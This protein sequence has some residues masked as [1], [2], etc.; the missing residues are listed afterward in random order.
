MTEAL[1]QQHGES[2]APHPTQSAGWF[3]HPQFV[4]ALCLFF[5]AVVAL[6]IIVSQAGWLPDRSPWLLPFF[7]LFGLFTISSGYMH[8]R[9]GYVSFDRIAQV[10]SI[11]VLGPIAAACVNGLA[12]LLWPLHRLRMGQPLRKVVIASLHNAGVMTLMILGCGLLYVWLSG[13]V[14]L[15][16]LDP[17]SLGQLLVL[18]LGMQAAN[19]LLMAVYLRLDDKAFTWRLHGFAITMEI[20][21]ALAGVLVAVVFNRMEPAVIV[22]MLTI[23]GLGIV[24]LKQYA[25]MRNRLEAIIE[26]RTQ[27]LRDKTL[28]LERLATRDQLTGL[29]N[30]RFADETLRRCIEEFDRDRR[31]FAVALIDLD[32]FKSINDRHS[33]EMGD[34]VLRQVARILAGECRDTDMLARYGG[35]EFL[36][37]FPQ[38]DAATAAGICEQLRAAVQS[39]DWSALAPDIKVTLS[40]GIAWMQPGWSPSALLNDADARLYKAKH[41]GRNRVVQV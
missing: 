39:A 23:F 20:G 8:P 4:Y 41:A 9:A 32:H 21:S 36:I 18:I 7:L 28:E 33:H 37:C 15:A 13:P 16:H 24:A 14:P 10:A 38:A 1:L 3:A 26:E 40:A 25:Q 6:A 29:F 19:E 12:S 30:R 27:V 35:E 5:A 2:P 17:H 31:D 34:E 22:L 11:L